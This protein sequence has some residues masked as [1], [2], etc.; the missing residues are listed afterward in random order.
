[1]SDIPKPFI[2]VSKHLINMNNIASVV[3]RPSGELRVTTLSLK[4]GNSHCFI[5]PAGEAA[6]EFRR[7]MLPYIAVLA[8]AVPAD[9][10]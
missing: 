10:E 1:M 8:D 3:E 4:G 7:Q 5:I 2:Q 9:E 6:T